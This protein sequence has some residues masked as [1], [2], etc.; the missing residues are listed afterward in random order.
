MVTPPPK[1]PDRSHA[2]ARLDV[3]STTATIDELGACFGGRGAPV[4]VIG[5]RSRGGKTQSE[6]VWRLATTPSTAPTETHLAT[7][8]A[9]FARAADALNRLDLDAIS[10]VI[11]HLVPN[12]ALPSSTGTTLIDP[13]LIGLL[14][15]F[16]GWIELETL[17]IGPDGI[18]PH[19]ATPTGAIDQPDALD[20]PTPA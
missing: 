11:S 7:L 19:L 13:D 18:A 9:V 20:Q 6:N 17:V 8:G 12:T 16:G 14:A 15:R 10:L 5:G 1:Q 3:A 2:A 4:S